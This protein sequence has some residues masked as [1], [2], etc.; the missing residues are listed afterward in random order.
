MNDLSR[1]FEGNPS[2]PQYASRYNSYLW[3]ILKGV[4]F[5]EIDEVVQLLE[6]ART[7][8]NTVVTFFLW[9]HIISGA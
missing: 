6:E 7:N 5:G 4:D 8:N 9:R 3:E 2:F 1:L